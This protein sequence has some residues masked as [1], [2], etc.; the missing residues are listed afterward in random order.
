MDYTLAIRFQIF[1]LDPF[2]LLSVLTRA[3]VGAI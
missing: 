3:F 2:V 1:E